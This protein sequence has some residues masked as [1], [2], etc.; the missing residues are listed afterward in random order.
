M[1]RIRNLEKSVRS[2]TGQLF[3]LRNINL[4]VEKGDFLKIGRA[5]V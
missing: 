3:L 2:G 4:V 1:I 5:H